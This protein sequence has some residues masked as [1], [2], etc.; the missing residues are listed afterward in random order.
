VSPLVGN[1]TEAG[2]EDDPYPP[3]VGRT[4]VPETSVKEVD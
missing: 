1:H 4:N 3:T 2:P